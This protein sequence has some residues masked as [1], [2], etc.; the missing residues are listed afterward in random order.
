MT[1]LQFLFLARY[2][3]KVSQILILVSTVEIYH[4]L[5][6]ILSKVSDDFDHLFNVLHDILE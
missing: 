3:K 6:S 5:I 2:P 1:K 4:I